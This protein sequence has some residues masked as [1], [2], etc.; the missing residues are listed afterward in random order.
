MRTSFQGIM[1]DE[2]NAV[3]VLDAENKKQKE[4]LEAAIAKRNKHLGKEVKP[5]AVKEDEEIDTNVSVI[6]DNYGDLV[7]N[8]NKKPK[9]LDDDFMGELKL[10]DVPDSD[11]ECYF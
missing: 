10:A 8:A 4:S 1:K 2:H 6:Q 3:L 9:I 7:I 11:D 5:K